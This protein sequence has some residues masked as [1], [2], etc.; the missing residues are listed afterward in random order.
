MVLFT[1]GNL[2]TIGKQIR[3]IRAGVGFRYMG[4]LN[5][6]FG[7][8]YF[9]TIDSVVVK[10]TSGNTDVICN[11]TINS[12]LHIEENSAPVPVSSFT[13]SASDINMTDVVDFTDNS[14]P[15]P[16]EWNWS[17]NPLSGW[18]FTNGTTATSENPSIAFN[19][20]GNYVVSLTATNGNGPSAIPYSA[21]ITVQN[22]VGIADLTQRID[23]SISKSCCRSFIFKVRSNDQRSKDRVCARIGSSINT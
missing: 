17:V 21:T 23:Q 16:F 5:A 15:C 14:S 7:I 19:D 12:V 11:P 13:V 18:N 1:S 4:T 8:S 22:V 6:H 10:W 2:W 20:A 9:N 3:G